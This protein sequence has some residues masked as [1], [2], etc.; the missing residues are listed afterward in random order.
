[1]G[2]LEILDHRLYGAAQDERLSPGPRQAVFLSRD[3]LDVSAT[4][5]LCRHR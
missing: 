4:I 3:D 2:P 5:V 1:M